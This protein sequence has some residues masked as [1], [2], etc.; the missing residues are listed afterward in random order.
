MGMS[1]LAQAFTAKEIF[2]L[3][4]FF[5]GFLLAFT[6]LPATALIVPFVSLV[7]V[8]VAFARRSSGQ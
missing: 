7:V 5:G 3:I 6:P 4:C 2:D 1:K 8:P